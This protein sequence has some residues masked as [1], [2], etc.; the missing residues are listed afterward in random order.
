ML[1]LS[2]P[3]QTFSLLQSTSKS[4]NEDRTPRHVLRA[5]PRR[6]VRADGS[7]LSALTCLVESW[8]RRRPHD[9][10]CWERS[11]YY[12]VALICDACMQD[13]SNTDWSLVFDPNSLPGHKEYEYTKAKSHHT[14]SPPS[15]TK[16]LYPA[17]PVLN[18]SSKHPPT[19]HPPKYPF[20]N[21]S[22]INDASPALVA[23]V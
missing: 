3:P 11:G 6:L 15:L 14:Q 12:T 19:L 7:C 2:L 4:T 1:T 20:R 22:G 10:H 5:P 18:M 21:I 17:R 13:K 16:P 9:L 8:P 23:L